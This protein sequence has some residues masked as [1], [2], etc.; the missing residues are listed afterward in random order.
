MNKDWTT[1][2]NSS[3]NSTQAQ[4]HVV[5]SQDLHGLQHP[6]RPPDSNLKPSHR[7]PSI[8]YSDL[9]TPGDIPCP[10]SHIVHDDDMEYVAE[11]C[12]NTSAASDEAGLGC[13]NID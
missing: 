9:T 7:N 2:H 11:T 3:P 10:P 1:I 12:E 4:L 5:G 8:P 6:P 13:M